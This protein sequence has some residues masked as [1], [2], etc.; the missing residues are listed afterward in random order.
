MRIERTIAVRSFGSPSRAAAAAPRRGFTLLEV[1]VAV[2]VIAV[3]A[4]MVAPA[5]E[6][7]LKA[8]KLSESV[9]AFRMNLV[10]AR[11][12]A[13]TEGRSYRVAWEANGSSYRIAPDELEDWPDLQGSLA[14]PL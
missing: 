7:W 5:F 8:Q 9:E 11:T 12:R 6:V 2:A 1:I 3:V 14:G 10:K 4:G 13:M